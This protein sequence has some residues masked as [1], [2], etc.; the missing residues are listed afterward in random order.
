M[1]GTQAGRPFG[2]GGYV[3]GSGKPGTRP[4]TFGLALYTA[5]R[6]PAVTPDAPADDGSRIPTVWTKKA[7]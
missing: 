2:L 3:V 7:R 4:N 5:P 6:P 1:K